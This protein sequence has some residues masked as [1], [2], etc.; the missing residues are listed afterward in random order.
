MQLIYTHV[1]VDQEMRRPDLGC[2]V[3]GHHV[4]VFGEVWV[5]GAW[6]EQLVGTCERGRRDNE[7]TDITTG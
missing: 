1:L 7:E 3:V 4:A 6:G 5:V 2:Q